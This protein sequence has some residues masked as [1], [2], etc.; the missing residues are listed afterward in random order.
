MEFESFSYT[1]RQIE[2]LNVLQ[3]IYPNELDDLRGKAVWNVCDF[4][5]VH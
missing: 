1:E 2:E 5:L 4:V 3:A